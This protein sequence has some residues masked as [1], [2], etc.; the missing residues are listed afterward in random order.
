MNITRRIKRG[1]YP[2]GASYARALAGRAIC[3]ALALFSALLLPPALVP[4]GVAPGMGR[5]LLVAACQ[6]IFGVALF[7]TLAPVGSRSGNV[8]SVLALVGGYW[9]VSRLDVGMP[10]VIVV[11]GAW[12]W[13]NTRSILRHW[14]P[15]RPAA[16]DLAAIKQQARRARLFFVLL[17]CVFVVVCLSLFHPAADRPRPGNTGN[18]LQEYILLLV[19]LQAAAAAYLRYRMGMLQAALLRGDTP[20]DPVA[21]GEPSEDDGPKT[22]GS[23][24]PQQETEEN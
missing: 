8:L 23:E 15:E 2:D 6:I 5:H 17:V 22:R 1:N 16:G 4:L 12:T 11:L 20:C 9:A 19:T 13:I 18:H 10:L 21:K 14:H 7:L 24:S 3:A